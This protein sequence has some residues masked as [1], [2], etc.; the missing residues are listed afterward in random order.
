MAN[1]IFVSPPELRSKAQQLRDHAKA[2]LSAAESTDQQLATLNSDQFSGVRADQ[3]RSRYQSTRELLLAFDD[4]IIAFA[5]QLDGAANS[6]E[7]ADNKETDY[8]TGEGPG[9]AQRLENTRLRIHDLQG[10]YHNKLAELYEILNQATEENKEF[11]GGSAK[12]LYTALKIYLGGGGVTIED[13]FSVIEDSYGA[14]DS[15]VQAGE[16]SG[17]ATQLGDELMLIGAEIN[18]EEYAQAYELYDGKDGMYLV[19]EQQVLK[20]RLEDEKALQADLENLVTSFDGRTSLII[21]ELTG[22]TDMDQMTIN[23]VQSMQRQRQI[24]MEMAAV[25]KRLTELKPVD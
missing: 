20:T 13:L 19:E 17:Q 14:I 12:I 21:G 10:Q 7:E 15:A 25:T 9:S 16:L 4:K 1:T 6:F 22:I 23:Y 18:K 5:N 2:I 24:E 3:L 8:S 11:V